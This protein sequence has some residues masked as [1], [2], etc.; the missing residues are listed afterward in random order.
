MGDDDDYCYHQPALT[1]HP[2]FLNFLSVLT[3]QIL[4]PAT[5]LTTPLQLRTNIYLSVLNAQ[6]L[7]IN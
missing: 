6:A 2:L 4:I 7:V 1:F 5:P 3:T